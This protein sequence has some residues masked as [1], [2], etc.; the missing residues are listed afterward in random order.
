MVDGASVLMQMT[1]AMLGGGLWNNERGSNLLDGGAPFY[2]TYACADGKFVAVGALEPKFYA[3]LL[4]GL[5]L[6]GDD[7]PGQLD[8]TRWPEL[9]ARFAEIFA[10]KSRDDWVELFAGADAC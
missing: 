7:L 6:S 9:R 10:S 4:L 5:G 1:W 8:R 2:D 3:A